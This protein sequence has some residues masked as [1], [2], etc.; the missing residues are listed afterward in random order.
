MCVYTYIYIYIFRERENEEEREILCV[1]LRRVY[2]LATTSSAPPQRS[3]ARRPA[4]PA[5]PRA[6]RKY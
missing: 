6:V 2:R 1:T 4:C 3:G 5:G